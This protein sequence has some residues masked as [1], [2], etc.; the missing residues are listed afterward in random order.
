MHTLRTGDAV[1]V[2]A[3]VVRLAGGAESDPMVR[4]QV[5]GYPEVIS[6]PMQC[7]E[8]TGETGNDDGEP[9]PPAA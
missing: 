1:I 3:R 4:L 7:C 6:L 9:L 8:K 5:S 2:R